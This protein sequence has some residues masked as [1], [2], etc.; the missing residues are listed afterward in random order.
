MARCVVVEQRAARSDR[1]QRSAPRGA[2]A[3][4]CAESR[5]TIAVLRPAARAVVEVTDR[6][7]GHAGPDPLAGSASISLRPSITRNPKKT[8]DGMRVHYAHCVAIACRP[9]AGAAAAQDARSLLRHWRRR[10][11]DTH[12]RRDV[13]DPVGDPTPSTDPTA[14]PRSALVW[15]TVRNTSRAQP[16]CP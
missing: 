16:R 1:A 4:G 9:R 13:A 11:P 10:L 6:A 12:R 7:A 5:R 3:G 8:K 2:L 15:L 14:R